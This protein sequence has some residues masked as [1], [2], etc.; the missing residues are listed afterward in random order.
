MQA[1]RVPDFTNNTF[2]GMLNWFAEMS[3]RGLLF[4]PDDSPAQIITI[5]DGSP[6][7]TTGERRKLEGI[8][9]DM[10]CKHGDRVHE[11]CYPIFMKA[12]GQRL[13]A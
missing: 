9:A 5:A 3:V 7:F 4:H 12:V 2:D 10:F 1:A 13:D 6:I 8:L 11:A